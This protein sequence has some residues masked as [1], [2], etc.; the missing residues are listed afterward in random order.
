M[1]LPAP[2]AR[3]EDEPFWTGGEHGE[4][5]ITRCRTCRRWQH[6]PTP[7]CRGCGSDEIGPEA[8]SGRASVFSFTVN[9]QP[10]TS[11][12]DVPYVLAIVS[13]EDDPA[14]HLTTRL[15]DVEPDDVRIGMA[16]TVR[17]EQ[18]GAWGLPLFA[19]VGRS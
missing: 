10:W 17:F 2:A 13:L 16:V 6:P 19:P 12:L 15:V 8:A 3:F 14:V 1:P 5:R 7:A 18:A 11:E 4:L 9:H